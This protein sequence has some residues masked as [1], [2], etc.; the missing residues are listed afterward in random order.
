VESLL[1]HCP[2]DLVAPCPRCQSQRAQNLTQRVFKEHYNP[3]QVFVPRWTRQL[4]TIKAPGQLENLRENG[5]V[6]F[7][8]NFSWGYHWMKDGRQGLDKGDTPPSNIGIAATVTRARSSDT[9]RGVGE[10]L[11]SRSSQ[12]R[13]AG[14]DS[15]TPTST[16]STRSTPVE[17]VISP[18]QNS[19]IE[20]SRLSYF[21]PR[22]T[23]QGPPEESRRRILRHEKRRIP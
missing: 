19:T 11:T 18:A 14:T 22:P 1:W 23:T 16:T 15:R 10:S 9:S 8:H 17:P 6:V 20:E 3:V 4:F 5:A 12:S 2:S 13:E 21:E 7:G